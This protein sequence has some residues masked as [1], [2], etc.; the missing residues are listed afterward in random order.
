[1]G[2]FPPG[3]DTRLIHFGDEPRWAITSRGIRTVARQ[4]HRDGS[5]LRGVDDLYMTWKNKRRTD[6]GPSAR[7]TELTAPAQPPGPSDPLWRARSMVGQSLWRAC[8]RHPCR[9]SR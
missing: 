8:T 7:L 5:P 2:V 6:A 1:M 3:D 4:R 9:T